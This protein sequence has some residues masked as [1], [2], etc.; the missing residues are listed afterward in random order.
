MNLQHCIN[1]ILCGNCLEVLKKFPDE[2][3][4]CCVTSPP[5]W[6][7]RN[8]GMKEQLGQEPTCQ[9]FIGK[10]CIIFDEI[11]RVLKKE[12]TCWVVLNDT[13]AKNKGL[14]LIPALFSI[15]LTKRQWIV[16]QKIVWHKPTHLPSTATDRFTNNF[17]E[18]FFLVKNATYWFKQQF[19]FM[20]TPIK[21]LKKK[22]IGLN[23]KGAS[24]DLF[25]GKIPSYKNNPPCAKNKRAVWS[26]KTQALKENHCAAYPEALCNIMI[27]AGCPVNGIVLDPFMGS[28]TSAVAALKAGRN[29]IGIELNPD[30]CVMAEKRIQNTYEEIKL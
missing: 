4:D 3:V 30:Y 12:G 24:K 21:A 7:L 8:Y 25:S 28:G 26:I 1:T 22:P 10:L 5:Y 27:R 23:K 16:R 19:D 2:S 20:S 9:E 29:F 6:Q 11:R 15:A 14:C 17:E 13:Y 18:I